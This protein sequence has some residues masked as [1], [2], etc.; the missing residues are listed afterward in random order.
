VKDGTLYPVEFKKSASPGKD[1]VRHF[2]VLAKLKIP[3]GPGGVICLTEQ[4]LPLTPGTYAISVSA[5]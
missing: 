5:I 2:Q 4:S 3:I 1:A